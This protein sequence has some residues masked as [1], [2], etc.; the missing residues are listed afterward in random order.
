M[1]NVLRVEFGSIYTE[2]GNMIDHMGIVLD[3]KVGLIKY[4]EVQGPNGVEQYYK[5]ACLAY[6]A[7]GFDDMADD[8]ILVKFDRY[9]GALSIEEVCTL[10]N[11]IIQ[12]TANIER[13]LEILEMDEEK[14]H[15]TLAELAALGY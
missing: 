1:K 3:K 5:K 14:I 2:S 11:Y 15:Y 8:L 9:N 6:R 10:C 12:C 13:I 7:R 4:G